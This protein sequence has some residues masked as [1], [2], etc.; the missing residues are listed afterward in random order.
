VLVQR[1][2]NRVVAHERGRRHGEHRPG[3][4]VEQPAPPHERVRDEERDGA[5]GEADLPRQWDRRDRRAGEERPALLEREQRERQEERD[6]P[7]Q[8]PGALRDAVRREREG[9]AADERRAARQPERAQPRAGGAAR[10][11]VGKQR[12]EV[13]REHGAE[14]C[15]EGPVREAEDE[16]LEV[17]A[18]RQLGPEAVRVVPERV[19][20]LELVTEQPQVPPRLQVVSRRRLAHRRCPL[21]EEARPQVLD[22]RPRCEQSREEVE[23]GG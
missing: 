9:K 1:A 23:L 4:S 14:E 13:P 6:R 22:R 3:H 5:H 15:E 11:D 17:H 18:W 2:A 19:R 12:E 16:P 21:G 20:M 10:S 7:E 8:V